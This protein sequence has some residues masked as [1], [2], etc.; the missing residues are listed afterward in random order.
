[1]LQ[2]VYALDKA[3]GLIFLVLIRGSHKLSSSCCPRA[4]GKKISTLMVEKQHEQRYKDADLL[5]IG[6]HCAECDQLDFLPLEC[7]HCKLQFCKEHFSDHRC[8][9]APTFDGVENNKQVI[10][11]PVCARGVEK[12]GEIDPNILIEEHCRSQECDPGNYSRVH[13]REKCPGV[14]CRVKLTTV[15]SYTCRYCGISTCVRH[16]FQAD[17]ECIPRGRATRTTLFKNQVDSVVT[18]LKRFFS[19]S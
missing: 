10:V 15:N 19:N 11:C 12:R 7:S 14:G 2:P 18:S 5:S 16:R 3:S 1:M 4:F 13:S 6:K 9:N 8:P 17:H